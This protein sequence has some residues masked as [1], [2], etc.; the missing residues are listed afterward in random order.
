MWYESPVYERLGCEYLF[1]EYGIPFSSAIELYSLRRELEI[2][3]NSKR[4]TGTNTRW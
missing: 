1:N 3:K 2:M 4:Y